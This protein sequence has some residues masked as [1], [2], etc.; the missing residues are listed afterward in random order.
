MI[1]DTEL[2]LQGKA[3]SFTEDTK[4]RGSLPQLDSMAVASLITKL[5]EQLGFEFP[6]EQLDGAIFES[7]GSLVDCVTR[8]LSSGNAYGFTAKPDITGQSNIR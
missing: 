4:L 1:L 6:E 2:N 8:I 3:L 7:V 5:E